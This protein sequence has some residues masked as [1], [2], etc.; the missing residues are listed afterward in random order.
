LKTGYFDACTDM[1]LYLL[2]GEPIGF[3]CRASRLPIV[4]VGKSGALRPTYVV[5]D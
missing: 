5:G 3:L 4:N 2:G 1:G